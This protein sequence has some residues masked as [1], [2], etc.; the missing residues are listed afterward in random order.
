[1][2]EQTEII[3]VEAEYV[4]LGS[5]KA[6]SPTD[7]VRRASGIASEL[8]NVID[9][10]KLSTRISGRDFVRVDG[11]ATLGAMLGVLPRELETERLEDG[12]YVAIVE[13]VRVSDGAIIGRGSALC[14]MDEAWGRRPEYARR[15]MAITRATAQ[16]V[17]A[18]SV[19]KPSHRN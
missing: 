18:L 14:G 12:G 9:G 17:T 15:S 2:N 16:A 6:S 13:L 3:T 4:Q 1:M 7:V 11:W 19:H 5:V 8:K 10:Q